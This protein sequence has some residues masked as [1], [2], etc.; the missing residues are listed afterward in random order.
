MSVAT[1]KKNDIRT[2]KDLITK[3]KTKIN[4]IFCENCGENLVFTFKNGDTLFHIS[5]SKI[6]ECLLIAEAEGQVP[7]IEECWWNKLEAIYPNIEN[8]RIELKSD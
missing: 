2:L 3:D 1:D 8:L 6:L 7:E 4:K 5:L